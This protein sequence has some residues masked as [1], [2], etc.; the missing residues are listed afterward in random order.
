[1][2]TATEAPA[3][4][5]AK[6]T[7]PVTPIAI[8]RP[9]PS[10]TDCTA[11]LS[12]SGSTWKDVLSDALVT[13]SV[14]ATSA[15]RAEATSANRASDSGPAVVAETSIA[16]ANTST[17]AG[18]ATIPSRSP[19]RRSSGAARSARNAR[20][21]ALR[22]IVNRDRNCARLSALANRPAARSNRMYSAM[23]VPAADR[24]W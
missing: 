5:N 13:P 22:A 24:T 11:S 15:I 1:M 23:Y 3:V 8:G 7:T 16:T 9:A 21:T 20:L 18:F 2:I 17:T 14:N 4:R 12:S 6:S 19:K 10:T